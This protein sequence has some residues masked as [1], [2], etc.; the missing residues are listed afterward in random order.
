MKYGLLGIG[1]PQLPVFQGCIRVLLVYYGNRLLDYRG[2]NKWLGKTPRAQQ[3]LGK[4]L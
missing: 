1:G 2:L 3:F 4:S